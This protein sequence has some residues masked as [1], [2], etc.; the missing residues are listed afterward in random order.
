MGYCSLIG[1]ERRP[2]A[3]EQTMSA[4]RLPNETARDTID[5]MTAEITGMVHRV[6]RLIDAGVISEEAGAYIRT[7]VEPMPREQREALTDQ[8][9]DTRNV[10]NRGAY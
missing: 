9:G 2:R 6:R 8:I 4:T 5:R 7:G 1:P 10:V 3:E